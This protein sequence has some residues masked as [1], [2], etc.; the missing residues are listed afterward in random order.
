[1]VKTKVR[2]FFEARFVGEYEPL[3]RLDNV[4]FN[5]ISDEDNESLVG[6]VSQEEVKNVVWSSDSSKSPGPNGFNFRFIMFCWVCLKEYFVSVILWSTVGS[7]GDQMLLLF[8]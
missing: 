3:V 1:V 4:R 6:V 2:D 8:V 7:L 5:S